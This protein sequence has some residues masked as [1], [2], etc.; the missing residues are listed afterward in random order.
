[1]VWLGTDLGVTGA[2]VSW[3]AAL[4]TGFAAVMMVSNVKYSSFKELDFKGRVPFVAIPVVVLATAVIAVYPSGLLMGIL[5]LY[6]VS[7]PVLHL[8]RRGD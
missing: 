8:K 6:A 1:M 4:L 2:E 7:G 5:L 3:L